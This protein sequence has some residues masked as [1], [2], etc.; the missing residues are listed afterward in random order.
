MYEF[1]VIVAPDLINMLYFVLP[2]GFRVAAIAPV[3]RHDFVK[4]LP[5]SPV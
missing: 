1:V 3:L 4:A 5:R 2:A